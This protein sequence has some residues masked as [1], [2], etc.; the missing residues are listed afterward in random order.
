VNF[1]EIHVFFK[2]NCWH[3][4]LPLLLVQEPAEVQSLR[5]WINEIMNRSFRQ[6]YIQSFSY[7]LRQFILFHRFL[8]MKSA[9]CHP[10]VRRLDFWIQC[11][12]A[13]HRNWSLVTRQQVPVNSVSV[14]F[15]ERCGLFRSDKV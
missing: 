7:S 3:S 5:R 6:F 8:F 11:D 1:Q 13:S 10:H 15:K 4:Q 14:L 9:E 12:M 2:T